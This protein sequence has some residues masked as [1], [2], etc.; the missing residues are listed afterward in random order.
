SRF[1][2]RKNM[3][4]IL[5]FMLMAMPVFAQSNV[6]TADVS[7]RGLTDKDFP[8]AVKLADNVYAFQM[9]APQNAN[10]A[11]AA[12]PQER[13]TTNSLVVITTDGVLIAD[14]QGSVGQATRLMEEIKKLTDQPVK[15]VVICTPHADHTGGNSALPSTA[16]F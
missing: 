15:Y 12:A 16:T 1:Q 7:K 6:Q 13:Y 10:A 14:G 3:K 4:R 9:L 11:A 5:A 8:Q 2:R